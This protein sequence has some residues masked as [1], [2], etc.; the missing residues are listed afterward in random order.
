MLTMNKVMTIDEIHTR[1]PSEWVLISNPQT[2]EHLKVLGRTVV[3]HS[4]DKDEVH[5]R[6]LELPVPRRIAVIYTGPLFPEDME[7][8]L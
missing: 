2:D 5:R 1:F 6:S 3:C 7:Y 8:A 4:N